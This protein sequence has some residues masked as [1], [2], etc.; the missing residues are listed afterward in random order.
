MVSES[1][2]EEVRIND[3]ETSSSEGDHTL[4]RLRDV[5][6]NIFAIHTN[7]TKELISDLAASIEISA[8]KGIY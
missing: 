4:V 6:V 1:T 5:W 3:R 8:S 7:Q 2:A